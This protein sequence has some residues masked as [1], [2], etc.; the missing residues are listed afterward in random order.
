MDN[1]SNL[2]SARNISNVVSQG[3]SD[4]KDKTVG[5]YIQYL[6]EAFAF[7]RVRRC[8][9]RGKKYLASQDKYYLADHAFRLAKL[10]S[11]NCTM[12]GSMKTSWQ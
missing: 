5:N 8:D 4:T 6:T 9:I 10:G 12:A 7:Y 1:I 3:S 11:K 2:T